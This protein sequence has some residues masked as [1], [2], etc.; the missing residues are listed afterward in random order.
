MKSLLSKFDLSKFD[1][2][3]HE[4]VKK[5]LEPNEEILLTTMLFKFNKKGKRQE[6]SLMVTN[7]NVFNLSKSNSVK[8]KIPIG[9]IVAVTASK[10]SGEFVLHVPEEYDYRYSS[11]DKR[12]TILEL[13]SAKWSLLNPGKKGLSFF[14]KDDINL[15]AYTTLKAD[16]KKGVSKIPTENPI[17]LNEQNNVKKTETT[18]TTD[19]KKERGRGGSTTLYSKDKTKSEVDVEDFIPLKVLGRGAFGKVM[20]VELK[21]TK[22]IFAMK[23]LRKEELIDKD[24]IEHT[25]TEKRILETVNHPFLVGLQ[26]VFQT[27]EKIFFVMEFMKGGELFQHLRNARRFTE[28]RSKFYVACIAMALG[29][30]HSLG[31]IYRDL[32]PENILMDELGFAYLT[33]FGMAKELKQGEVAMSFCGTPEYLAPE[34]ITGEGHGK[35]ADWWSLGILAYETMYGI[36]PFYNQNQ[37]IM[38]DLIREGNLKFPL[39]PEVSE[40]GK[41]FIKLLLNQNAKKRI[42]AK[43]DFDEIKTHAWFKDINWELLYSK[44]LETPFKP[45]VTGENWLGNFDEEFTKEEAIN[46]YAPTNMEL[47][48]QYQKEFDEFSG[49]KA[50]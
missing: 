46:S 27:N 36:P 5:S 6:R 7:K 21:G 12:D 33:D 40:E 8:R 9:K 49:K 39:V 50:K 38:Y 31:I 2:S 44:D 14:Y 16:K 22:E 35:E 15:T 28:S 3:K 1:L 47:I 11:A 10:M 43:G 23:S 29:H 34:I 26:Y 45:K 24:Q 48:N 42:G 18:T 25:K 20:L 17:Y 4:D 41:D 13:L 19:D 32:K 30:L 37:M